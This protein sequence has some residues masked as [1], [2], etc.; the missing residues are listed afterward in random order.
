M[1]KFA[2]LLAARLS[3]N[4]CSSGDFLKVED[5]V[6]LSKGNF[7]Q[8]ACL[9]F[10]TNQSCQS[11]LDKTLPH[12][13]LLQFLHQQVVIFYLHL[14]FPEGILEVVALFA[15]FFILVEEVG[16]LR[17]EVIQLITQFPYLVLSVLLSD[18]LVELLYDTL[19]LFPHL[20]DFSLH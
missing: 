14:Q 6:D 10:L 2:A 7:L 1:E 12:E 13:F 20:L 15:Y 4:A 16:S 8:P 18:G 9:Y 11:V 19:C 3:F 5:I 17:L